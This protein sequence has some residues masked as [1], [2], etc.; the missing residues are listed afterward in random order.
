MSKNDPDVVF[1]EAVATYLADIE[2][3][4]QWPQSEEVLLNDLHSAIDEIIWDLA[5][6]KMMK[7]KCKPRGE[8]EYVYLMVE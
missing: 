8:D 1:A 2:P 5:T 7:I 4:E 6:K 3:V